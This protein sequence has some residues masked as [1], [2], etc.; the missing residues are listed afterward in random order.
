[1]RFV[2][3]W[4]PVLAATTALLI[5]CTDALGPTADPDGQLP[6][7]SAVADGTPDSPAG[8]GL[9]ARL[10][11]NK[12]TESATGSGQYHT[13]SGL[14]RT[15]SFNA[16]KKADDTVRGRFHFRVHDAQG[17]GS[18]IW[19][20]VT[21]LTIEGKEAWLAGYVDKAGNPNNV[22]R[23]HGFRV[24]DNG[25]GRSAAPDQITHT[26]SGNSPT[27]E[28]CRDK[29]DFQTLHLVEAGNV[30]IHP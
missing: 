12:V 27:E 11:R 17:Q 28:Y 1:M 13:V 14:W 9:S 18:R 20:S 19:G 16:T 3:C 2:A 24:A 15:F 4:S 8:S 22:G 21:C 23:A 10:A 30:Q 26:W 29:P 7:P 25:Q 5:S 6:G